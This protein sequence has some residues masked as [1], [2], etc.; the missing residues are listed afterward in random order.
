MCRSSLFLFLDIQLCCVEQCFHLCSTIN[1]FLCE[2]LSVVALGLIKHNLIPF[3]QLVAD[4]MRLKSRVFYLEVCE[5]DFFLASILLIESMIKSINT[6]TKDGLRVDW[7]DD[8]I[9]PEK[10][11]CYLL[12]DYGQA[13]QSNQD[14]P[15]L[16]QA[17]NV[18]YRAV[19]S[20]RSAASESFIPDVSFRAFQSSLSMHLRQTTCC[21]KKLS[22]LS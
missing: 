22:S 17:L 10:T 12:A 1:S 18:R 8:G 3:T 4:Y 2:L 7:F 6:G 15:S 5:K 9:F 19:S 13:Y 11:C 21:I 20:S 14:V 16:R